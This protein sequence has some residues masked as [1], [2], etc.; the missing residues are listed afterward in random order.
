MARFC[1]RIL[2]KMNLCTWPLVIRGLWLKKTIWESTIWLKR[3]ISLYQAYTWSAVLTICC[4]ARQRII[5]TSPLLNKLCHLLAMCLSMTFLTSLK[6]IILCCNRMPTI[7][8]SSVMIT[9]H[10]VNKCLALCLYILQWTWSLLITGAYQK[11]SICEF[12]RNMC[13]TFLFILSY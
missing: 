2:L 7:F 12:V 4:M 11:L 6:H 3:Q 1:S 10:H 5:Q 13:I 8:I 9:W